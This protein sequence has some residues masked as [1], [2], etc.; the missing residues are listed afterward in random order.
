MRRAAIPIAAIAAIVL[1]GCG[2]NG[3]GEDAPTE[4]E[5]ETVSPEP[6]ATEE[7]TEPEG[8]WATPVE[9]DDLVGEDALETEEPADVRWLE[10]G[11][12]LQIVVVGSG[13]TDCVPTAIDAWTDGEQVE[14]EFEAADEEATCT[15]DLRPHVWTV[16]WDEPLEV[17]GALQLFLT[18]VEEDGEQYET[19]LPAEPVE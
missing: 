15:M 10:V 3:G 14:I 13:S 6:T 7:P 19:E 16:T 18:N 17:E 11:E 8:Q 12:T 5:T 4:T 1:A 9:A 2:A